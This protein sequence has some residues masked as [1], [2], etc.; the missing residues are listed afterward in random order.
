M[1]T[2][3]PTFETPWHAQA[4]GLTVHL[5]EQGLFD[6]PTWTEAFARTLKRRG[7]SKSLDGGDDYYSA[8]LETL[9]ALLTDAGHADAAE[10]SRLKT[11][12]ETAYLTTPHGQPVNLETEQPVAGSGRPC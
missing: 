2:P 10:I 3:S 5:H 1:T 4:F 7:L 9:E 12:W 11:A 6:W 8:W